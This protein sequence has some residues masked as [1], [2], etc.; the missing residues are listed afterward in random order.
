MANLTL[1]RIDDEI[2][3]ILDSLY[4]AIDD[5]G[6]VDGSPV[7]FTSLEEL[8]V[9]RNAKIDG[10]A[11][12]IKELEARAAARKAE[13]DRLKKLADSDTNKAKGLRTYLALSMDRNNQKEF[14][15]DKNHIYFRDTDAVDI[16]DASII[17]K[18][19]MRKKVSFEPDKKAIK[20]ILMANGK[21]RGASLKKN[22][23]IQIK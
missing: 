1:F 11:C 12:Y 23:N 13:S 14:D 4:D 9:A 22:H 17:P 10:V 19:Y 18:K 8:N 21:V 2:R 6:V 3:S 20:E 15:S 5:D 7:D 16:P